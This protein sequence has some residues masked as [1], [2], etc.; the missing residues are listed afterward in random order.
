MSRS[1]RGGGGQRK[2]QRRKRVASPSG[3]SESSRKSASDQRGGRSIPRT[4]V[5]RAQTPVALDTPTTGLLVS[6]PGY[7]K[8]T[9]TGGGTQSKASGTFPVE[10]AISVQ[11]E[12]FTREMKKDQP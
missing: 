2:A 11:T 6:R 8:L 12:E 4:P 3:G 5:V 1:P 7:P 10:A 9:T